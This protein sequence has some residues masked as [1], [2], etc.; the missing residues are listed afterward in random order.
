MLDGC[1]E[2]FT[3]D[4]VCPVQDLS[5]KLPRS[6]IDAQYTCCITNINRVYSELGVPWQPLKD[7]AFSKE[8]PFTSF[9]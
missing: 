4:M 9:L 2:E 3:K 6:P 1:I 5:G 8:F 7:L